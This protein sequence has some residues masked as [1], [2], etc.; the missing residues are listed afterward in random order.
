MSSRDDHKKS[1]ASRN[2]S[3]MRGEKE[4]S[5]EASPKIIDH[6]KDPEIA[7]ARS[8]YMAW[9]QQKR[10]EMEKKRRERKEAE[11][12]QQRPKWQKKPTGAKSRKAKSAEDAKAD[13]ETK[14]RNQTK[15]YY[16]MLQINYFYT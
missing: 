7:N 14:A 12:E 1:E 16:F 8:R 2:L 13:D 10:A 11:E 5:K 4:E 15:N 3:P 6:G 9:Y